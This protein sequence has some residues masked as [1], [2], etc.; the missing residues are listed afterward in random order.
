MLLDSWWQ[1]YLQIQLWAWYW[2]PSSIPRHIFRTR[3]R[4]RYLCR[5]TNCYWGRFLRLLWGRW[6]VCVR[7]RNWIEILWL[8]TNIVNCDRFWWRI[9]LI[10]PFFIGIV[11]VLWQWII[12]NISWDISWC[13]HRWLWWRG[14]WHLWLVNLRNNFRWFIYRFLGVCLLWI[15]WLLSCMRFIGSKILCWRFVKNWGDS[16]LTFMRR[17][18]I[19]CTWRIVMRFVWCLIGRWSCL[20]VV[21]FKSL[22]FE[23]SFWVIVLRRHY[24]LWV[25]DID[26]FSWFYF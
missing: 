14:S 7:S 25:L 3:Y 10:F 8:V 13:W 23:E 17:R 5:S 20:V 16:Y 11:V 15:W 2:L 19:V 22:N 1:I 21:L 26:C 6:L 4:C 18:L 24:I 9:L 12:E